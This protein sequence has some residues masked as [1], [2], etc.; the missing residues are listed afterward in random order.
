MI[1]Y[2][3][4][5]LLYLCYFLAS[6]ITFR[7]AFSMIIL[8]NHNKS[9]GISHFPSLLNHASINPFCGNGAETTRIHRIQTVISQDEEFVVF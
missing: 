3:R 1:L 8:S 6:S 5:V 7:K 4:I 2:T 9:D